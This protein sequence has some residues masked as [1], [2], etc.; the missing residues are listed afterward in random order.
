MEIKK[1]HPSRPDRLR[2][3]LLDLFRLSLQWNETL[4]LS[5]KGE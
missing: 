5:L 3:A 2:Q 4:T 1:R